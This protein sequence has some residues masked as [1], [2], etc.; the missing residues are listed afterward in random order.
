MKLAAL[1]QEA[2]NNKEYHR[3]VDQAVKQFPDDP[4]TLMA[5]VKTAT[6]RKAYKKAAGFA[7]RVL[8]LDPINTQARTVLIN[9]HLAHARK[10]ILAGKYELATKELDSAGALE[11][12][13]ARSGVVEI[14]RGLLAHRQRQREPM[15]QW[16]QEGVRLAGSPARAWLRLMVEADRLKLE[17][18]T[19]LR[20]L[21]LDDP[22]QFTIDRTDLLALIQLV[23]AYREAGVQNLH[24]LLEI[25]AKPLKHAITELRHADDLLLVCEGLHQIPDCKLLK[26]EDP[27]ALNNIPLGEFLV[28]N[29]SKAPANNPII[30]QFALDLNGIMQVTAREKKTGLEKSIRIDNVLTQYEEGALETARS[31]INAL[32]ANGETLEG[33]A[34]ATTGATEHQLT[35]QARALVE[36]AERLL[37]RAAQ[38][39]REEM[40]NLIEAINDALINSD[41]T[42][43]AGPM[44]ELSDILFYLES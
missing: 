14:D 27:D 8:E 1:H 9:S 29:L 41:F 18:T 32:F 31:R 15:R 2:G 24:A 44:A 6:A 21:K 11:R 7:T 19:I 5:A 4:L 13:N 16:L 38:D 10:Q 30:L 17:A 3:W 34:V 43:L 35:A 22:R 12:E 20:D 42:A 26:Y 23:N 33:Q 25:L 37:D 39:D 36:K 40:I 28:E